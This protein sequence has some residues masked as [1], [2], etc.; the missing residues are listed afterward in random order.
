M[1]QKPSFADWTATVEGTVNHSEDYATLKLRVDNDFP[2][3][4]PGQFVMIEA[5]RGLDPYLRRAFS[6]ATQSRVNGAV[7]LEI[8]L[9]AVGRGTRKLMEVQPGEQLRVLGP[10]GQGFTESPEPIIIVAGGVG[11]AP[12]LMLAIALSHQRKP[13]DFYYGG[14]SRVDLPRLTEVKTLTKDAGGHVVVT[15]EDGTEGVQGLVTVPLIEALTKGRKGRI[16]TCGPHG[17]MKAL[18]G[19]ANQFGL[20]GEAALE[21]D[22]GCGFGACLGCVVQRVD[23][24]FALCCKNGPVF[25]LE[26]IQW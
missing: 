2:Q 11:V 21:T 20:R 25:R 9:K 22:M 24:T 13:F 14:R 7:T 6:V 15:T 12:L 8:L 5:G 23:G 3:T 1:H 4:Q 10:L 16:Y 19:I 26:D 18:A 17:L